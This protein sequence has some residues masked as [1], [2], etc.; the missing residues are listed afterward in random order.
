MNSGNR[1]FFIT[2]EGIEGVGKTTH[3]EFLAQR[4]REQGRR[5]RLTREPGGTVAGEAI[6]NL[7]LQHRKPAA[8]GMVELL[9][10]FAARAQ[11]LAE[12]VRPA[13][14]A[15]ETVVCDRFT[16]AT[17]AYQGGGRGIP[18]DRIAW[19]EEVVQNGLR[20]DM[21]L[22]FDAPVEIGLERARERGDGN[23]FEDEDIAFF[24]RVRK[25]Y[26]A[27]AQAET[28]RVRVINVDR[29]LTAVQDDLR[30]LVRD[31]PA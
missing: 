9:L 28:A 10:I 5:V 13:L 25:T 3:A 19:L 27:I 31:L 1:G 30:S 8:D 24:T 21:T 12:V 22:L 7:L 17:Y 16:D 6:R 20:P 18:R 29:P 2:L 23:R 26:L 14:A 15:G 11:H 4:L